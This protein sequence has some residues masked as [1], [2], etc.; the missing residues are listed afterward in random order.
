MNVSVVIEDLFRVAY[1]E[2]PFSGNVD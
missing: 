2:Y 1:S